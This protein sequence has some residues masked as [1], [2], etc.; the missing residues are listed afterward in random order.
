MLLLYCSNIPPE[1]MSQFYQDLSNTYKNLKELIDLYNTE[2]YN[3][4]FMGE[5]GVST[6]EFFTDIVTEVMSVPAA[7]DYMS[8]LDSIYSGNIES[9][10]NSLN[11]C[12]GITVN[13]NYATVTENYNVNDNSGYGISVI[14]S[15][16]S[17]SHN[18]VTFNGGGIAVQGDNNQI[19]YN[20]ANYNNWVGIYVNGLGN[21][22]TYS[23]CDNNGGIG[24]YVSGQNHVIGSVSIDHNGL[25]GIVAHGDLSADVL[26]MLI[27]PFSS[28]DNIIF[29]NELSNNGGNG[30]YCD[31]NPIISE[32]MGS[33]NGLFGTLIAGNPLTLLLLPNSVEGNLGVE[34]PPMQLI[35]IPADVA[36][37]IQFAAERLNDVILSDLGGNG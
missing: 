5:L 30:I 17:V 10:L 4:T 29:G 11:D 23:Q 20:T 15:S 16:E 24:I 36:D 13:G 35:A 27:P 3:S 1:L 26:G 34:L 31:G 32:N 12:N 8:T 33:G 14:G 21:N 18:I 2:L 7:L 25:D 19:D 22:V 9:K 37:A 6:M 28:V